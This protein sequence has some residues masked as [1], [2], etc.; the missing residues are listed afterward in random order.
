MKELPAHIMEA[1]HSYRPVTINGFTLY[2]IRVR[3][4]TQLL[5]ARQGISFMQ[6]SL[7]VELMN[8]PFLQALYRVDF[9][10]TINGEPT[11][12]LFASCLVALAYALRLTYWDETAEEACKRFKIQV[13]TENPGLLKGL[14]FDI[15]G[16]ESMFM[17]P[18]QF[19]RVRE[20]IAAQNGISIQEDDDNP[21]LVQAEQ[22]IVSQKAPNLDINVYSMVHSMA[23]LTHTDENEIFDWPILKLHHR[24]ESFKK[25]LDYMVCGIGESQGTKWKG[26]NPCPNPWF[27]KLSAGKGGL[28]SLGEFAGGQATQTVLE[29]AAAQQ[30]LSIVKDT[31]D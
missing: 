30:H 12:G 23:A 6:Q 21:E 11:T 14:L 5:V 16:D 27:D 3:N 22:D 18:Q 8:M 26:G 15:D 19:N 1:V 7:P 20:I 4:Y 29:G 24:M 17:T 10:R 25:I 28:V 2:P 9:D 31:E 13:D